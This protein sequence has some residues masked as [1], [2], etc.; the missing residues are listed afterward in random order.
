MGKVLNRTEQAW[1]DALLWRLRM[2]EV[3][4]TRIGEVLAEVQ[5]HVAETG[6]HPR[7]A[8]GPAKEYADRVAD[9]LGAA[10]PATIWR[11]ALAGLTW[12]DLVE[13]VVL[14]LAAYL[15]ADGLWA[16]TAGESAAL[17]LPAWAVCLVAAPVLAASVARTVV[18][19]RREARGDEVVDPR[20]GAN[21]VP[22]PRWT[23]A[24]L[25][26]VPVLAL[27]ATAVGG[28]LTR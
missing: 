27:V 1:S 20:T 7:E 28:L 11:T 25:F 4:G 3:P 18:T 21:M 17:G 5:S 2:R 13:T 24:V 23:V 6:E 26:G 16:L 8:F 14:G 22:L 10:P 19:A 9:A 15:L 12:W